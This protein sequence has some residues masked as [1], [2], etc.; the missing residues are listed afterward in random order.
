M[1]GIR[2]YLR[3]VFACEPPYP[4]L[5]PL[6]Y[7]RELPLGTILL[8][9]LDEGGRALADLLIAAS[10]SPWCPIA[11]RYGS[12]PA[13]PALIDA[14]KELLTSPTHILSA[15]SLAFLSAVQLVDSI[16]SRRRP[17]ENDVVQYI[18]RRTG[19]SGAMAEAL[20]LC[21][22]GAEMAAGGHGLHRSTVWRRLEKAKPFTPRDWSAASALVSESYLGHKSVEEIALS[23]NWEANTVRERARYLFGP[24][25]EKRVTLVGWEWMLE[26]ILRKAR[27]VT[28]KAGPASLPSPDLGHHG[29]G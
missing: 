5:A 24:L 9:D 26:A 21:I 13:D 25:F 20:T 4:G 28:V 11:L 1:N 14:A 27:Y 6:A 7:A 12:H 17:G 10:Q 3:G 22:R 15:P 16:R 8:A 29:N 19:W 18:L 23:L 2:H